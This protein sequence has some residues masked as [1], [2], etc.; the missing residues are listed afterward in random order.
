MG[1]AIGFAKKNSYFLL[2]GLE[3]FLPK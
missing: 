2:K 3:N 1:L